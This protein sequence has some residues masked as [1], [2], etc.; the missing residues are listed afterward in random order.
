MHEQPQLLKG[1]FTKLFHS[2]ARRMGESA[3]F[4]GSVT[5]VGIGLFWL[6]IHCLGISPLVAKYALVWPFTTVVSYLVNRPLWL[7]DQSWRGN[8]WWRWILKTAALDGTNFAAF[9]LCLGVLHWGPML[10]Y[11]ILLAP[12]ALAAYTMNTRWVFNQSCSARDLKWRKLRK[13]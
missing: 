10:S 2:H 13:A 1:V 8:D 5:A 11:A 4:S 6:Y 3:V 12:W 7:K 9:A